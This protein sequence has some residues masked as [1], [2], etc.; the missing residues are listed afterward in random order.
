MKLRQ[1]IFTVLLGVLGLVGTAQAGH[2]F[3]QAGNPSVPL[4][5]GN[6]V[7]LTQASVL[8][9]QSQ[10][11]PSAFVLSSWGSGDVMRIIFG[12][13]TEKRRENRQLEE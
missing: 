4:T 8:A 6:G 12:G 10:T 1:F 13:F 9:F 3:T 2:L 5:A 11:L 7:D